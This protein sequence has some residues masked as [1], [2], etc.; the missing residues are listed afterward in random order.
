MMLIYISRLNTHTAGP[1]STGEK[2]KKNYPRCTWTKVEG[3]TYSYCPDT[4][5]GYAGRTLDEAQAMCES[6]PTC[7]GVVRNK[8]GIFTLK[9]GPYLDKKEGYTTWKCFDHTLR[10][11]KFPL[12]RGSSD[13]ERCLGGNAL[14]RG[15]EY[16]YDHWQCGHCANKCCK[17]KVEG[18][19]DPSLPKIMT[20][21]ILQLNNTDFHTSYGS[22]KDLENQV[23]KRDSTLHQS[24]GSPVMG[25]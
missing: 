12:Q 11:T 9:K 25:R 24:I 17:R 6:Q 16:V 3:S 13:R 15:D 18:G 8:G 20:I 14:R 1:T 19:V 7:G 5:C 2:D 23:R 22:I 10:C 21:L 4:G